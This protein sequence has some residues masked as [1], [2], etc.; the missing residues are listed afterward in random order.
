MTLSGLL[1]AIDG[2]SSQVS[3]SFPR[4][5][6]FSRLID[7][8]RLCSHCLD[9]GCCVALENRQL[10]LRNHPEHLDPALRR[11]GRFDVQIPFFN[12]TPDQAKGL[13]K[14]FYP[15]IDSASDLTDASDEKKQVIPVDQQREL[16]DGFADALFPPPTAITDQFQ[17]EKSKGVSMAALQGY[18][19]RFKDDPHA[20]VAEARE[21]VDTLQE[22][23]PPRKVIVAPVPAK[24]KKT[25]KPV[26]RKK[27]GSAVAAP[28]ILTPVSAIAAQE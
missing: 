23:K 10:I 25:A 4:D 9:V 11:A 12:A 28:A 21:W 1:N 24:A 15:V 6:D 22:S 8:G 5:R 18:L 17:G 13:F 2:V 3:R 7:T 19:L 20:A 27:A 14:H 26:T 16:A